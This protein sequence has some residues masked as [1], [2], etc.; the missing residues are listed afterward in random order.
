MEDK[1]GISS[2]WQALSNHYHQISDLKIKD[3]FAI[4]PERFSE[5]S[6]QA[7][8]I[9]LDYSK[10]RVTAETMRLLCDLAEAAEVSL[11]REEMFSGKE[12]N[13][14]EKRAVLHTALRNIHDESTPE[15]VLVKKELKRIAEC[16]N[17]I[18]DG[19]W[20][21]YSDKAITDVVN[22]G[23][24]GS[25][26]GPAM[27]VAA[28]QPY[29][30]HIKAHFVSNIDPTHISET[31]K[32][33]N[34]ETT[35]FIVTSKTFTTQETL[36]NAIVAREWLLSKTTIGEKAIKRHFIGVT[37]KPERAIEFGIEHENVF[38]FW[39]WVGGRFS[40]W[41]A[42]GLS[43]ALA[44]GMDK[45]YEFL[46]GAYEMDK[47]FRSAPLK[48]N[49]PVILALLSIWNIDFLGAATQAIIPYDQYLSLFPAYLQQLE[50]ESNG[51][52]VC[53]DGSSVSYKTAP[54]IWGAVGTN[55]QHSFHQL[56]M[57]GT[58][59]VPVDF[60]I[61][62]QT[63]NPVGNQHLLLY[64]NCL[65][66]SQALMCGRKED[67]II[68]E[69]KSQKISQE[70]MRKLLPH[71][72]IPGNIPSNTIVMNKIEPATLGALIA[73]YEHKVFVQG[74]IW[75][76]NSFDQWGVELGKQM[77]S[78]L[79]PMLQGEGEAPGLDGSTLGLIKKW[80]PHPILRS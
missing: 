2:A 1:S 31:I 42:V 55:S 50:M 10:N 53:I 71:K 59:I 39:D 15:S 26:L 79:V 72:I 22:I 78:K 18:R 28:L 7:A 24:G 68:A 76:I 32:Y 21:G 17:N 54:V 40:L 49:M 34:P 35:V 60:I 65:A 80:L 11:H 23:I 47:H 61:S 66:Q 45:F 33:L 51:K 25:D 74:I 8:G 64:A 67:D 41:S 77:A 43:V 69:L 29:V 38:P 5:F 58:Q 56:L 52:R 73:F 12:I 3:Q 13:V 75:R 46:D 14:T 57:Q 20:C 62:L 27:V 70:E 37:S 19:K 16:V 9:F 44:I 6:L 36:T 63:H 30:N 4:Y 48:E